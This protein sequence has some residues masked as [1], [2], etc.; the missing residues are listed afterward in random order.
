METKPW[1]RNGIDCPGVTACF[2]CHDGKGNFILSYRGADCRDEQG[3][4]DFGGG[5]LKLHQ[6]VEETLR[7]EIM[8]EYCTEV[9]ASEFL[10]YRELH[11]EIDGIKTHWIALDFLVLIDPALVKNGEP[12]KFDEVRMFRLDALPKPLHSQ[13]QYYLPKYLKRFFLAEKQEEGVMLLDVAPD[14]SGW[15]R[16]ALDL[17][18]SP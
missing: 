16:A 12:H 13:S 2:Y 14:T 7:G 10:G 5:G 4:W 8:Q 15:N 17:S 6:S 3:T 9:L 18:K 1:I 11:R